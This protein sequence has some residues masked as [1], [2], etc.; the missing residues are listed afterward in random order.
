MGVFRDTAQSIA[1][2]IAT[3]LTGNLLRTFLCSLA[4]ETADEYRKTKRSETKHT[5][6]FLNICF[7]VHVTRW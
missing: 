4:N 5:K 1:A 2:R 3:Q 7:E 6:T